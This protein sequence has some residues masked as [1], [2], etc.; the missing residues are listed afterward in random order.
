MP[1]VWI[2]DRSSSSSSS[3]SSSWQ[4]WFGL[5]RPT[6]KPG[7]NKVVVSLSAQEQELKRAE[8]A[9]RR[10]N[11][12]DQKLEEEK[13]ADRALSTI[14]L[15]FKL[16][17]HRRWKRSTV[18]SRNRPPKC[19]AE[20]G[21]PA[22]PLPP[23]RAATPPWRGPSHHPRQPWCAGSAT[24][25][26]SGWLFRAAGWKGLPEGSSGPGRRRRACATCGAS[27][28]RGSRSGCTEP[29]FFC[30]LR[31]SNSQ[32]CRVAANPAISSGFASRSL[33]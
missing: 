7:A 28:S 10:K 12:T 13:V 17:T 18:S 14:P 26:A 2:V 16:T 8:M 25:R 31:D 3:S 1:L 6:E 5:T 30:G 33:P 22:T 21:R 9:R 4:E 19:V 27:W 24:S 23:T 32:P 29:C 15:A 11:L 20:A